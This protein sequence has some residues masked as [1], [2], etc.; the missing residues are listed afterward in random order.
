MENGS[1]GIYTKKGKYKDKKYGK[2]CGVDHW[3]LRE[4]NVNFHTNTYILLMQN[5]QINQTLNIFLPP[6]KTFEPKLNN[7]LTKISLHLL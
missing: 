4:I 5:M 6:Q 1:F 2:L 3:I 7:K